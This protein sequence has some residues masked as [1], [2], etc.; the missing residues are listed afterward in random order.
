MQRTVEILAL[1]GPERIYLLSITDL[2]FILPVNFHPRMPILQ[3]SRHITK[4]RTKKPFTSIADVLFRVVTIV[5]S[6]ETARSPHSTLESPV[7]GPS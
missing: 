7:N 4:F 2:R 5:L 6:A 1:K 3:M